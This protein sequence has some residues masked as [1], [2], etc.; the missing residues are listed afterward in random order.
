MR[1]AYWLRGGKEGFSGLVGDE[2]WDDE[3]GREGEKGENSR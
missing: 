2:V 1:C 3:V